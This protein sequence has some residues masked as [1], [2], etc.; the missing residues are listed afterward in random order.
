[1]E[2]PVGY[3][4]A[5]NID[6]T[7]FPQDSIRQIG[8]MDMTVQYL[9]SCHFLHVCIS[10]FSSNLEVNIIFYLTIKYPKNL[11]LCADSVSL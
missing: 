1:M 10:C 11:K 9:A 8:N 4:I 6:S 7:F 3:A 5:S 2:F